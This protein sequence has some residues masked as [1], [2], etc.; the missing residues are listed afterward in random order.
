MSSRARRYGPSLYTQRDRKG[1]NPAETTI[2]EIAQSKGY[3]TGA[4]GKWHL[5]GPLELQPLQH[6]FEEWFGH[7]SGHNHGRIGYFHR[8]LFPEKKFPPKF[9]PLKLFHQ[10][11]LI[12]VEPLP[13]T[14]TQRFTDHAVDFI[15]STPPDQP[16]LFYFAHIMPH[17]PV[18]THKDFVGSS[19]R[20]TP[21]GDSIHEVDHSVGR[22][23]KALEDA[24]R[25]SDTIVVFLSDNGGTN[26]YGDL[27][28]GDNGPLRGWKGALGKE[29]SVLHVSFV[30]LK[31]FVQAA[32]FITQ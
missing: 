26:G 15:T 10:D 4:T 18:I 7:P 27:E 12:E 1:L 14:L 3:R 8:R 24:Q 19:P 28:A 17:V 11:Q 22:L 16:F 21:Y 5:G 29:A 31:S 6:G 20:G 30:G 2:A 13:D 25:A 23:L 32:S 9:E